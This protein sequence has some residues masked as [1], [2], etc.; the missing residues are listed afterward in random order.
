MLEKKEYE[1]LNTIIKTIY[2]SKNSEG[3]R[4][5]V[6]ND[7]KKLIPFQFSVFSLGVLKN[8]KVYLVDSV[9]VSD[10]ERSFEERFLYLSETRYDA[11]D[12]ASWIFQIPESVVYKDSQL[13]NNFLRKKTA[14]YKDYLLANDLPHVAGISI[15][16]KEKFLGAL[17]LYKTKKRGDFSEKDLFV[18]DFLRPHLE[19]R[20]ADDDSMTEN[21]KKNISYLLRSNYHMTSREIEITGLIFKG[22]KNE[23]IADQL[24]I[25]ENTVKKHVSHVYDKLGVNGR[26]QLI[27][28]ILDNDMAHLW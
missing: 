15:V 19:T 14:Y 2:Q 17:T 6:L 24:A 22:M 11:A 13:V 10:F 3:M 26:P 16:H 5:Q 23:E 27:Q 7:L 9:L 21:N 4:R 18:L 28:F 12:Y 8:K 25:A 1:V 20:L